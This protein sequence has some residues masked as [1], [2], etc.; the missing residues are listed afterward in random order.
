[1]KY[2]GTN[3]AKYLQNTLKLQTQIIA[4]RL[5]GWPPKTCTSI[6]L[7][8]DFHAYS[9]PWAGPKDSILT[10]RTQQGQH[11][12]TSVTRLQNTET[13]FL[14]GDSSLAFSACM[15]WRSKLPSRRGPCDK[16]QKVASRQQP[17]KNLGLQVGTCEELNCANT[18]ENLKQILPWLSLQM[19]PQT[20]GWHLD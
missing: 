12:V 6:V 4:V 20:L 11:N 7:L 8:R 19:K 13:S 2:L 3:P 9:L 5:L 16:Q 10:N 14:L 15:F 17:A 18:R 1:M